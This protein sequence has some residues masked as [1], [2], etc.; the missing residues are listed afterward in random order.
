MIWVHKN[1]SQVKLEKHYDNFI[2]VVVY[3]FALLFQIADARNIPSNKKQL[4][5]ICA[6]MYV[7]SMTFEIHKSLQKL[8]HASVF[9]ISRLYF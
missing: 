6:L 7:S 3:Y 2:N 9:E 8:S 4:P 5:V 1:T